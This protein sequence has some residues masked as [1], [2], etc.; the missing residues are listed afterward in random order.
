MDHLE[1]LPSGILGPLLIVP[2]NEITASE[3]NSTQ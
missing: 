1:P 2:A 3:G